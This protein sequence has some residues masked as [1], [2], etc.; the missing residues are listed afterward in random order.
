MADSAAATTRAKHLAQSARTEL[1]EESYLCKE[2]AQSAAQ[3]NL[4]IATCGQHLAARHC[5]VCSQS[6]TCREAA[7][8]IVALAGSG[9]RRHV[10][11]PFDARTGFVTH[12]AEKVDLCGRGEA[13]GPTYVGQ[14][15]TSQALSCHFCAWPQGFRRKKSLC[16]SSEYCNLVAGPPSSCPCKSTST[17]IA[18]AMSMAKCM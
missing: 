16:P 7:V 9:W 6:C 4:R 5:E 18:G 1:L 12:L 3:N 10:F 11:G 15:P 8:I 17:L 13:Q 14:S 2:V